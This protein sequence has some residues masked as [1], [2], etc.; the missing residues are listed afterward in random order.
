MRRHVQNKTKRN[1]LISI[2]QALQEL[3]LH[4][5]LSDLIVLSEGYMADKK[6]PSLH[7]KTP[8]GDINVHSDV[9]VG[10]IQ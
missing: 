6:G 7:K 2:P 1:L 9:S 5:I 8:G 3:K 10:H 4:S